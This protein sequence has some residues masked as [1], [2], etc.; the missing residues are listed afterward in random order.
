[1][2]P[3]ANPSPF[4]PP[5]PWRGTALGWFA[6]LSL[7]LH[8]GLLW[9]AQKSAPVLTTHQTG[10]L[11]VHLVQRQE[12]MEESMGSD[13]IEKP[14]LG[15]ESNFTPANA[16]SNSSTSKQA[17][18]REK[19]DP[20][21]PLPTPRLTAAQFESDSNL[22]FDTTHP[23]ATAAVKIAADS[24]DADAGRESRLRAILQRELAR[25]FSYPPLARKRGWEGEVLLAFR[26]E[27]DGR[28]IDARVARSSGYGALD[29]AA[30]SALGKI[31][32][33]EAGAP[34]GFAMQL[35]VIYRLE[36]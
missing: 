20:A 32:R 27:A 34:P 13:S 6:V 15:S 23:A 9:Q 17:S 14:K 25:H 1:M 10:S 35:P 24:S 30:L 5:R 19:F 11:A 33:I 29:S 4:P 16:P 2:A 28:I 12:S 7:L 21:P 22:N 26:L 36:G 3:I 8:A 31:K 18:G